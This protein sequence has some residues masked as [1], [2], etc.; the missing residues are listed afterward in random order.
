MSTYSGA[1]QVAS[2]VRHHAAGAQIDAVPVTARGTPSCSGIA[3]EQAVR[4]A[5]R[6]GHHAD[7]QC[8]PSPR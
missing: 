5:E 6:R 2:V 3:R 4:Q 1:V 8:H 7:H